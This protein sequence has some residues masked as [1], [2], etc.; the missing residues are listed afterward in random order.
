MERVVSKL[1]TQIQESLAIEAF[2]SSGFLVVNKTLIRNLGLIPAILL[3]NYIDKY[4]YFKEKTPE[5]DGWFYLTH[6]QQM[7][8]LGIGEFLIRRYKNVLKEKGILITKTKGIP[9]KEWM[10]IDF[11][12]L[13]TC[14]DLKVCEPLDP[15]K[16]IPLD[17]L[18]LIPH[19][20]ICI[21]ENKLKEKEIIPPT[22]KMVD[23]YCQERNNNIDPEYFINFYESKGWKVGSQ[24]MKDWQAA[25][26]TW[27][28]RDKQNTY[29]KSNSFEEKPELADKFRNR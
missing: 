18:K 28:G 3:S 5:N 26:R 19:N 8:Q 17:P 22:I 16:L 29:Q 15:L 11:T 27:E 9:S 2:K 7:D 24:R 13:I 20:I 23:K 21:K 12:A 4:T 25:V 1:N 6:E 10:R 14:L